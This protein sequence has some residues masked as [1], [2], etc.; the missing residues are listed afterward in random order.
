MREVVLTLPKMEGEHNLEIEV[1]INGKVD[2]LHYR[3][4]L[5]QWEEDTPTT[6]D[7]IMTLRHRIKEYDKDWKLIQIGI[8]EKDKIP[9]VFRKMK[10]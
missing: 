8:P 7:K 3:V 10:E 2:K 6:S 9:L 4:E 1:R 5:V